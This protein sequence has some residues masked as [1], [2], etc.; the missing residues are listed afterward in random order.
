MGRRAG[1]DGVLCD[2]AEEVMVGQ[3][4]LQSWIIAAVLSYDVRID[5]NC[6]QASLAKVLPL[7][8]EE[9]TSRV[10]R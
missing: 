2:Y 4:E 6:R 8:G 9:R 1:C 3:S 7:R 10:S 5:A